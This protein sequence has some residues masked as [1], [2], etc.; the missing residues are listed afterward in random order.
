MYGT[1]LDLLAN[2]LIRPHLVACTSEIGVL[3]K[4]LSSATRL[5]DDTETA[6]TSMYRHLRQRDSQF[7]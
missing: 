6:D 3:A 5:T 4:S 2:A 1:S 7:S